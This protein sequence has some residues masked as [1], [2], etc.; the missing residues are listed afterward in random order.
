MCA[1]VV[2]SGFTFAAAPSQ[3]ASANGDGIMKWDTITTPNSDPA[4]N[5]VLNPYIGGYFTGSEIR[6]LSIGSDGTTLIAAVTVDARYINPAAAVGSLGILLYTNSGGISWSTSAYLHLIAS[7]GWNIANQ[8]YNVLIAP[9]DP[10]IWAV[11]VGTVTNGPTEFW[12]TKDGGA[13]WNSAQSPQLAAGEAIS[14]ID[15]SLDYGTGRDLMLVTRFGLGSGVGRIFM[16]NMA[17]FSAW[18]QQANP[19][20][21]NVDFFS[22][23]FSPTYNGDQ[24]Y[25]LIMASAAGTFYNIGLRDLNYNTTPAWVYPGAGVEV[26]SSSSVPSLTNAQLAVSDLSLPSDFSG[27]S[28]GLRRAFVSLY[29]P[30]TSAAIAYQTGIFRIDDSV[31]TTLLPTT[32]GKQIYSISFFGTY[33]QGKLVAGLVNGSPCNAIVPTIYMDTPCTCVVCA[34]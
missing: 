14:A 7:K 19:V 16:T 15:I 2:A 1:V 8:V 34:A 13:T 12:V 20:A 22:A 31:V 27:Q 23:K 10:R 9:G 17:G 26:K 6:D 32:P 33:V 5:D 4:R 24:A 30:G 25:V 29:S 28:V 3:P 11:T 18:M 21:G